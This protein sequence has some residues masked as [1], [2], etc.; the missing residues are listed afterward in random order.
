MVVGKIMSLFR[1]LEVMD[2]ETTTPGSVS[3]SL[4]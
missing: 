4:R 3:G 2:A 1:L